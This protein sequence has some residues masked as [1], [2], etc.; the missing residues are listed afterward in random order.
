MRSPDLHNY[1]GGIV[2]PRRGD[3]DAYFTGENSSDSP[4]VETEGPD[5][6]TNFDN[7]AA[8]ALPSGLRDMLYQRTVAPLRPSSRS[9]TQTCAADK[10]IPSRP[11]RILYQ[12]TVARRDGAPGLAQLLGQDAD[13]P[14]KRT[15]TNTSPTNRSSN[16]LWSR[17]S[18]QTCAADKVIPSRPRQA[19]RDKYFTNTLWLGHAP[20]RD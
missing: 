3:C 11:R 18:A 15:A 19:D 2:R 8:S 5:L 10:I 14:T 16:R 6:R 7:A 4:L 9:S 17:S 13:I 1:L 12:R 20:R